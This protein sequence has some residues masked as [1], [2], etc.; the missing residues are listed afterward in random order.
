[1]GKKCRLTERCPALSIPAAGSA[2]L[3]PCGLQRASRQEG[4]SRAQKPDMPGFC[5][6]VHAI[7][8]WFSW[9]S[10]H[11]NKKCEPKT[12]LVLG[13]FLGFHIFFYG[14]LVIQLGRRTSPPPS[15]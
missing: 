2:R 14:F 1:M 4:R 13:M 8:F 9:F 6:G 15:D 12:C 3:H 11:P 10:E 5:L 7:V